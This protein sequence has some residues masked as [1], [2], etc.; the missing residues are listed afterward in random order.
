M[1]KVPSSFEY[2]SIYINEKKDPS[3]GS[4]FEGPRRVDWSIIWTAVSLGVPFWGIVP[5]GSK[6]LEV[7][8]TIKGTGTTGCCLF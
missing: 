3:I 6:R 2:T 8:P 4:L 7:V 5:C 1:R